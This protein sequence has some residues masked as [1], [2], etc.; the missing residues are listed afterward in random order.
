MSPAPPPPSR[1]PP[2]APPS[3]CITARN[4]RLPRCQPPRARVVIP[5]MANHPQYPLLEMLYDEHHRGKIL[6][7]RTQ[8]LPTDGDE[9]LATV[10]YL[11]RNVL[12]VHGNPVRRYIDY[13]N[14]IDCLCH[15]HG[16][17]V[18]RFANE[19]LDALSVP[20]GDPEEA[21]R[22]RA[23]VQR[24]HRGCRKIAF[25]L[26]CKASRDPHEHG[27]PS[28]SG[29]RAAS[30]SRSSGDRG[31]RGRGITIGTPRRRGPEVAVPPEVGTEDGD[32]EEDADEETEEEDE[33][34]A[35][36]SDDSEEAD[37]TYGQ[38]EIG[39]SQ[40]PDAPSQTQAS[41]PAK[42]QARAR[43][44]AYVLSANK[45]PTNPGRPGCQKKPFTPNPSGSTSCLSTLLLTPAQSLP[46]QLIHSLNTNIHLLGHLR[47]LL[48]R[49]PQGL[50]TNKCLRSL[51]PVSAVVSLPLAGPANPAV[52]GDSKA[53]PKKTTFFTFNK[54]KITFEWVCE[55]M[56][57]N[58]LLYLNDWLHFSPLKIERMAP[59][60]AAD[61]R[62]LLRV[63]LWFSVAALAAAVLALRKPAG[64][65]RGVRLAFALAALACTV[66]T[67]YSKVL[68]YLVG[69]ITGD[70]DGLILWLWYSFLAVAAI[71]L[72]VL[73][74]HA[75]VY[76]I[77]WV[78]AD[79]EK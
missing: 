67:H 59:S 69:G 23:F 55:T 35:D 31:Q 53:A 5:E 49:H 33:E 21:S 12:T 2:V 76:L 44:R 63:M 74:V 68:L 64:R 24:F 7:E 25:K 41:P 54:K 27:T 14:A 50:N 29:T 61:T 42:R 45:L 60:Q 72:A 73:D 47:P 36:D 58:S 71:F 9:P 39:I 28:S 48:L 66:A 3:A 22:L 16:Q 78:G 15:G 1:S 57:T 65:R 10:G 30:T 18:G 46:P 62:A 17:Q 56:I 70:A 52:V 11:W 37:P 4:L 43:D 34:D 6:E 79:E 40:L 19:S 38:E 13:S 20:I 75:F 8:V 32:E 26:N 51:P 77:R